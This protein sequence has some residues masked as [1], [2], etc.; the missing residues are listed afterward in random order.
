[1]ISDQPEPIEQAHFLSLHCLQS[2]IPAALLTNHFIMLS[3][4][5]LGK[6][7]T[8]Y[9]IYGRYIHYNINNLLYAMMYILYFIYYNR[10][11]THF[12]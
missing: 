10:I 4:I 2:T 6:N 1:M 12:Y 9:T 8:I 3:E 11:V 7:T 5:Q